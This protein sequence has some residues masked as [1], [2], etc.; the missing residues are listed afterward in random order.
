MNS[1][2]KLP[3]GLAF[4]AL[5]AASVCAGVY[6][7]VAESSAGMPAG[8]AVRRALRLSWFALFWLALA[9]LWRWTFRPGRPTPPSPPRTPA[10][11]F[12]R[13]FADVAVE[14][15]NLLVNLFLFVLLAFGVLACSPF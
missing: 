7:A 10:G 8:E 5:A 2:R 11:F 13:T 15:A 3:R 14:L 6:Y 4:F 12:W 1:T 9:V